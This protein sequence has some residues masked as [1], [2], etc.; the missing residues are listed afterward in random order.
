VLT[1]SVVIQ[2]GRIVEIDQ[3]TSAAAMDMEGDYVVPGLIDLHTDNFEKHMMPRKGVR[4]PSVLA[5]VAQDTQMASAGITTVFDALVLGGPHNSDERKRLFPD[6]LAAMIYAG[7]ND[8]LRSDH[9]LHIRCEIE[10]P[11]IVDMASK[12]ITLP[13]AGLISLMDHS[14]RH[15]PADQVAKYGD[16]HRRTLAQMG[17]SRNLPIASHDDSTAE[18]VAKARNIGVTI[19]EFPTSIE[20]AQ[21]ARAAGLRILGGAPNIVRGGSQHA[22]NLSV[23]DLVRAGL[24]D[25]LSSDYVPL[26]L[27]AAAFKLASDGHLQLHKAFDLVSR[28]PA[29]AAGLNDRGSIEKGKL[30]DLVR[31]RLIEGIPVVR[32]VWKT[33]ARV[34]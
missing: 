17:V 21:A 9:R 24:V 29:N 3:R 23:L 1:G 14:H 5:M 18:Q 28:N 32:E 7:T 12:Y 34:A 31:V 2:S 30:A 26:S 10:D 25:I 4:W 13:S 16:L 6:M 19:S 27:M 8:M 22:G 33:G 15:L 11:E 20:A